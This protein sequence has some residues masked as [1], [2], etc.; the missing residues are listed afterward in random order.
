MKNVKGLA[1]PKKLIVTDNST[2]ITTGIGGCGEVEQDKGGRKR[3]DFG[4]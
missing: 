2:V 1:P 4:W 3:L